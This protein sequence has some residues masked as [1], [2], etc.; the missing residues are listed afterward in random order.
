M[1]TVTSRRV[2]LNAC[3]Y[4]RWEEGWT[5]RGWEDVDVDVVDIGRH[6]VVGYCT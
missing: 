6:W 4:E 2:R 5:Q 1:T 3:S